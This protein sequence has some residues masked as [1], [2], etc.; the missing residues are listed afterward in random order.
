MRNIGASHIR[1]LDRIALHKSGISFNKLAEELEGHVSRVSLSRGLRELCNM[2]YVKS[3]R[4]VTHRQR[5]IFRLN[6]DL[7]LLVEKTKLRLLD[8]KLTK[9]RASR[10]VLKYISLYGELTKQNKSQFLQDYLKH[11]LAMN[12]LNLL[13]MLR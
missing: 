10:I 5:K 3:V 4:D 9:R 8:R 11:R 7:S 2:G 13:E 12:F 6:D 1:I